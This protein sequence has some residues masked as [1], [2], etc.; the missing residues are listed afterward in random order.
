MT[1]R[2]P[3]GENGLPD[4]AHALSHKNHY[5]ICPTHIFFESME[6]EGAKGDSRPPKRASGEGEQTLDT[7]VRDVDVCVAQR[8]GQ[9]LLTEGARELYTKHITNSLRCGARGR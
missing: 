4:A 1:P 5:H 7:D 8:V 2:D 6:K 9:E 3:R